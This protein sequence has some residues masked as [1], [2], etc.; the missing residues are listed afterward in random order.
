MITGFA[1]G[2]DCAFFDEFLELVIIHDY[3]CLG[4]D[5]IVIEILRMPSAQSPMISGRAAWA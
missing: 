3:L 5:C 4:L 2:F 1:N